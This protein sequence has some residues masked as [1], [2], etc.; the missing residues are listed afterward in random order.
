[1]FAIGPATIRRQ[2]IIAT[3][4]TSEVIGVNPCCVSTS[5]D[6]GN[7][8]FGDTR[9]AQHSRKACS[10][11]C[12]AAVTLVAVLS[13]ENIG[14]NNERTSTTGQVNWLTEFTC[15]VRKWTISPI[16]Q[17]SASAGA[18]SVLSYCSPAGLMIFDREQCLKMA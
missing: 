9:R 13:K 1:M 4:F 16:L 14:P 5:E 17:R 7:G 11:T 12:R 3:Q 15:S 8:V 18:Q 10:L 6:C 2:T